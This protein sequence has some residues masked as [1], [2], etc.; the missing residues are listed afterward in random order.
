MSKE[1][2]YIATCVYGSYDCPEVWTLR[3]YRDNILRKNLFG[4]LLV[5]VY[6]LIS[7]TLVRLFGNMRI[8][9]RF[10]KKILDKKIFKLN[11]KGISSLK[12]NDK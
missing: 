9:K 1:G 4:R 3:R 8:F 5:R 10:F 7:P 11:K 2:C 6:Y 12:Y